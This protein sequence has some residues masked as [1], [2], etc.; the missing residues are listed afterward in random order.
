MAHV[1]SCTILMILEFYCLGHLKQFH[2]SS[3]KYLDLYIPPFP[4]KSRL[5][6]EGILELLC[7][8]YVTGD[9]FVIE[10]GRFDRE[11]KYRN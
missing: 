9:G 6:R 4:P 11:T 1:V 3:H 8:R 7:T 10:D 5:S 2:N